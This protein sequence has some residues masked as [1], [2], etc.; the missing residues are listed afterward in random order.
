MASSESQRQTELPRCATRRPERSPPSGLLGAPTTQGY[1][2]GGRKPQ[3]MAFASILTRGEKLRGLPERSQ[4]SS[5]S[6]PPGGIACATPEHL[7]AGVSRDAISLLEIFSEAKRRS[8]REPPP[9]R[10]RYE[11][12]PAS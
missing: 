2:R 8:W 12:V 11:S 9:S 7:R 10:H 5:P 6:K 4:S 1:S 3:A